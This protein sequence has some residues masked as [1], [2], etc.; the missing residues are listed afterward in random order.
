MVSSGTG[1]GAMMPGATS[2]TVAPWTV[3]T[4]VGGRS[5]GTPLGPDTCVVL[6]TRATHVVVTVIGM[7]STRSL[8]PM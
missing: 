8:T 1:K 7:W 2:S 6:V 5:L 4:T 3:V